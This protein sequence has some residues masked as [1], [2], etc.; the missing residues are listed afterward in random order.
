MSR[1]ALLDDRIPSK[2]QIPLLFLPPNGPV[3]VS[4]RLP[5]VSR[6]RLF[7][8][9]LARNAVERERLMIPTMALKFV[10]TPISSALPREAR[11]EVQELR[12][13]SP[14]IGRRYRLHSRPALDSAHLNTGGQ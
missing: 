5:L 11:R 8:E 12:G 13:T 7:F 2:R 4:S 6:C 10:G 9:P 1:R 14:C 3:G